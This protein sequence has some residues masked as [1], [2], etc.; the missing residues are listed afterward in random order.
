[1]SSRENK[2][3]QMDLMLVA[4][5]KVANLSHVTTQCNLYSQE[6]LAYDH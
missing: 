6:R 2:C 5:Y 1:M 4:I 3:I